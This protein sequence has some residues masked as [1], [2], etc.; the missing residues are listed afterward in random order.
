MIDLNDED[1]L[2]IER[3]PFA[4]MRTKQRSSMS[5]E[6]FR[7]AAIEQFAEVG[8]RAEV[9]AWTTTQE[10]V[11]AF[12]V[13]ITGRT[14]YAKPFD[15]DQFVHEVQH[16]LLELPDKEAGVIK[17]DKGVVRDLLTGG[18]PDQRGHQH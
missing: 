12:D 5:L 13:E 10:G 2:R 14:D 1:I 15:P 16:N 18:R 7:R 11:Y 6:G 17:T 8:F 9:K 3:G 4:W